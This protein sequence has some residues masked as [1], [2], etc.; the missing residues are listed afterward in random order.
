MIG[1][2]PC[3]FQWNPSVETIL[4]MRKIEKCKRFSLFGY[5]SPPTVFLAFPSAL[6]I[7]TPAITAMMV[8]II[9]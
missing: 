3:G 1:Y 5:F 6:A 2:V 4:K 8:T 7:N 9:A